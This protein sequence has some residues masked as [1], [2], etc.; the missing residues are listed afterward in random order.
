MLQLVACDMLF[1][2]LNGTSPST[3]NRPATSGYEAGCGPD[4]SGSYK[5]KTW[6]CFSIPENNRK[7]PEWFN[8]LL[9]GGDPGH[10]AGIGLHQERRTRRLFDVAVHG[11]RL[12]SSASFPS[13]SAL[14]Q[15]TGRL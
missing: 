7:G 6:L 11:Q 14:R 9:K 4:Q 3:K 10:I 13:D 2:L 8:V 1:S 15:T 5:S 12:A